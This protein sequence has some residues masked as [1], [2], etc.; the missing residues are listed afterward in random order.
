MAKCFCPCG[1]KYKVPDASVGKKARC[2]KCGEVFRLEEE[3]TGTIPIADDPFGLGGEIED[4]MARA[5]EP[6]AAAAAGVTGFDPSNLPPPVIEKAPAATGGGSYGAFFKGLARSFGLLARPGSLVMFLVIWAM[7]AFA[8]I[9]LAFAGCLGVIGRL[10]IYGWYCAFRFDVIHTAA[11][12]DPDLPEMNIS[13]GAWDDIVV[14]LLKWI[15]SWLV[16]ILPAVAALIFAIQAGTIGL[17]ALPTGPGLAPWVQW[18]V[19][20]SLL[21]FLGAL[22]FGMFLWPII[23]MAI[24]V[25]GFGAL[26]QMHQLVIAVFRAFPAYLVIVAIVYGAGFITPVANVFESGVVGTVLAIGVRVYLQLVGLQA[27]GLFYHHFKDKFP[28]DWG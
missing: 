27:I 18:A 21:L 14:P 16:V 4:A 19:A 26:G 9:L 23:I 1:A 25:A 3:D 22:L 2:K 7:I 13:G 20:S 11:S 24:A 10:I 6:V 5:S 28:Y 15:G 12:G 17:G 8:D